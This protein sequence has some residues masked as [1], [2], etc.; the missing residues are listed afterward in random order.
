M[1]NYR[2]TIRSY[3]L[4]DIVNS[5]QDAEVRKLKKFLRSPYFVMRKDV[6]ALFELLIKIKG[7][8]QP[9]PPLEYC[10]AQLFPGKPFHAIKL[11]G[12]MSDLMALIEEFLVNSYRSKDK[13]RSRL[14]LSEIFRQRRLSKCF[15][16]NLKKTKELIEHSPLRTEKYYEQV[17]DFQNE[18]MKFALSNRR[19]SNLY[20]Q[21]IS[22]TNDTLYLIRKLKA[23]CSQ[24]THQSVYK[25][26]Y[27]SGLLKHIINE[28]ENEGYLKVPAVAIFYYC[29]RF[30][31][32]EQSLSYF[33]KFKKNLSEYKA[34]FTKEDLSGH[35]RL[36]IN[37]CIRKLNEG[38]KNYAREGWELYKEGLKENILVENNRISRF[39]FN[40]MVAMA[41]LLK[42]FTWVENFISEQK[43]LLPED[44]RH[45]TEMF[46]FARLEFARGAF[47][48]A[49]IHLQEAEYKDL[50]NSLIA[51]M[52][53][54]KIYYELKEF[55]TLESLLDSFTQFIRRREVSDYHSINFLNNI[56]F[57]RK[58]MTVPV[59]NKE[60]RAEIKSAIL[61]E[62][63]VSEREWLL[64]KVGS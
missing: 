42:K 33:Q 61:N 30:L 55:E 59:Y 16:S 14:M 63:D 64:E 43:H 1:R 6:V 4:Y 19:T 11:R 28:I 36:G 3:K 24:L 40:N 13:L 51:K 27:D 31:S 39:T 44:F 60:Q 12:I 34:H 54:I 49:L 32:E 46:N 21:E 26:E 17:L 25:T 15:Q 7:K 23:A 41:L 50:V 38:E 57:L 18:N 37:Y 52:L 62:K 58:I 8:N 5:L 35:F 56:R 53:Q 29:F 20:F 48:Q 45:Q 2:P 22:E 10:F 9:M 47:G